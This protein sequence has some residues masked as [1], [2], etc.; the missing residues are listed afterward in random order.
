M[1]QKTAQPATEP[2]EPPRL[3]L[4]GN[5]R[6]LLAN[7]SGSNPCDG[8]CLGPGAEPATGIGPTGCGPD[9]SSC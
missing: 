3:V 6:D 7:D 1:D 4:V 2:Y 5:I 9:D 8:N